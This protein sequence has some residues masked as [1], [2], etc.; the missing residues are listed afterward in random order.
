ME[1]FECT[2][3]HL[4]G[5]WPTKEEYEKMHTKQLLKWLNATRTYLEWACLDSCT[6]CSNCPKIINRKI[7]K[8]ILATRPHIPNKK[9]SKQIRIERIKRGV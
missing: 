2:N 6:D 4:S 3:P 7:I 9:E 1:L 8:D 5:Y